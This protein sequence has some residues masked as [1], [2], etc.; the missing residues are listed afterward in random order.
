MVAA[1]TATSP[2]TEAILRIIC[3]SN[4]ESLVCGLLPII[5]LAT[6]V[7]LILQDGNKAFV[8]KP[9][10][11]DRVTLALQMR[12]DRPQM[13]GP[14]PALLPSYRALH[15]WTQSSMSMK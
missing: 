10:Y 3:P 12:L 13:N 9:F 11:G 6:N 8:P 2:T 14:T 1:A 4:R 5:H 15:T 7:F